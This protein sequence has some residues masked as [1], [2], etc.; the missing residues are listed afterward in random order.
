MKSEL[1]YY[2]I[3]LTIITFL[4]KKK[5][6]IDIVFGCSCRTASQN[7]VPARVLYAWSLDGDYY[8]PFGALLKYF[9]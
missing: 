3:R 7:L 1:R 9:S 5:D 4:I 2:F 6:D 8:K